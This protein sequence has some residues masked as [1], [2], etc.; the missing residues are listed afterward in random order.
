MEKRRKSRFAKDRSPAA[1]TNAVPACSRAL[2]APILV[3]VP[4]WTSLG[5]PFLSLGLAVFCVYLPVLWFDFVYFDDV[6]IIRDHYHQIG[7]LSNWKL[8]FTRDAFL[9]Q[10]P[11]YRPLQSLSF[12]V[13]ALIGGAG[14]RMYHATNLLLHVIGSFCVYYLLRFLR[15]E[16]L[17]SLAL[18]H[19]FA[20]HP[21]FVPMVAWVPTRGDLFL[22]IFSVLAFISFAQSCHTGRRLFLCLHGIAYSLALLSKETA[23]VVPAL[24]LIHYFQELQ[25]KPGRRMIW[26]C[27]AIW[28]VGGGIWYLLRSLVAQGVAASQSLG[29]SSALE[30]LRMVPELVAKLVLPLR[31]QLVPL[32]NPF[33]TGLGLVLILVIVSLVF[34]SR[35][36]SNLRLRLGVLWFLLCL[37]PVMAFRMAEA[38]YY[39]DYLYHRAYVPAVGLVVAL[40]EGLKRLPNLRPQ[41]RRVQVLV[42]LFV[43]A[44]F[45]ISSGRDMRHYSD[46]YTFYTE[47][48]RRTPTNALCHNNRGSYRLNELVQRESALEDFSRALALYPEYL[49]AILNRGTTL[50]LL[51]RN[52]EALSD[53]ERALKLNPTVPDVIMKTGNLRYLL[54]DYQ[55]ALTDYDRLLVKDKL[56][57]RIYS[58]RAGSKAM[59]GRTE[60]ALHDAERA[61]ETDARDEEAWNARGI[62]YQAMGRLDDAISDFSKAL[63]IKSNYSRAYNNRGAA[64]LAKQDLTKALQD[65]VMA[66]QLDPKFAEALSNRG[67][68][69]YRL[70]RH[71]EALA[72]L[73]AAVSLNPE[74]AKAY[75]NRS[76]AKT[77]L[78]KFAEARSD[79]DRAIELQPRWAEAYLNRGILLTDRLG[80]FDAGIADFRRALELDPNCADASLNIGVAFYKKGDYQTAVNHYSALLAVSNPNPRIHYLR[81]L[82]SAQLRDFAG[83]V[84]DAKEAQ[85]LGMTIDENLLATWMTQSNSK[86]SP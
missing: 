27:A 49:R 61:I 21:L 29:P 79:Y 44:L 34:L 84:K 83:A 48:I 28:A 55:G 57:P 10:G 74:S 41:Y 8:A 58:K 52:R 16:L 46:A 59:L 70:G 73:D 15:Y 69:L 40:A 24:C 81:A 32:F 6:Q 43:W 68:A 76:L 56:Y 65:F 77:A 62:T 1:A 20:L 72:D 35:Y 78:G 47:A 22:M 71:Q 7:N 14:A 86:T 25:N 51:G 2:P 23:V 38:Q 19:L 26:P 42:G 54:G 75:L 67:V 30:N 50:Q 36:Q 11:F 63:E 39:F 13:D 9:G 17:P 85:R 31:L 18:A 5:L 4:A 45:G 3:R 60:E 53:L 82:A 66:V 80:Q 33:D 37:A 12:M 64:Y